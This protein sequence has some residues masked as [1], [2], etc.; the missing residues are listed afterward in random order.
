VP[1]EADEAEIDHEHSRTHPFGFAGG[2]HDH[3]TGLVRFGVRDYDASTGRWTAKDPILFSGSQ[4]SL[5]GYVYNDPVNWM[6]WDGG[7]PKSTL[8]KDDWLAE[9]LDPAEF[10]RLEKL[11]KDRNAPQKEKSM[12]KKRL[13]ELRRRPSKK[14]QHH[15]VVT[16]CDE[17][18]GMWDVMSDG[19][20]RRTDDPFAFLDIPTMPLLPNA[21]YLGPSLAPR[22]ILL[23]GP[24][25]LPF[26][27]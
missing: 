5:Y 12:A 22:P 3:L 16:F 21:P 11:S 15:R 23:K 9:N 14:A 4:T 20:V 19:T 26:A 24:V 13:R 6:D 2:F 7:A 25:L 17:A 27:P 10:D 1:S 18:G 8:E